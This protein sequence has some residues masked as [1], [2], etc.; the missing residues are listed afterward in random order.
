MVRTKVGQLKLTV[1]A[2]AQFQPTRLFLRERLPV[3]ANLQP[4]F[5]T[6]TSQ[7]AETDRNGVVYRRGV[8]FGGRLP[9]TI[10]PATGMYESS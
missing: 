4:P 10:A 8:S 1:A 7:F 5:V 6:L 2:F 3:G 9:F